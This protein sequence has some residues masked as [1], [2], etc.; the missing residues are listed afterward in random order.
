MKV[1]S[2]VGARPQFIKAAAVS[3]LLR[4]DHIEVL[5]HT[6]QH[7]DDTLSGIFFR[8][9]ALPR[10]EIQ[11]GIGSGSHAEQTAGMLIGLERAM[12]AERPDWVLVYGDTNS[13]L[14]GA[15]AAAKLGIKLAHVEAGLRSFNRALPEE[16]NRVVTDHLADVLLCPT[17]TAMGHLRHE[18]LGERACL[19]GDVMVDILNQSLPYAEWRTWLAGQVTDGWPVSALD[20][21]RYALLT[22]HRP[23]NT[24]DLTRLGRILCAV[25][26]IDLPVLF[27]A[28]PRTL[29]ALRAANLRTPANMWLCQPAPYLAMLGLERDARV[30][31]TDSGGVQKEAYILGVPCVTLRAETEWPETLHDGWNVLVD[32][33]PAQIVAAVQRSRPIG[34]RGTPFGDGHAAEAVVRVLVGVLAEART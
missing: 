8:E 18:G 14:A 32:T 17:D 24:D 6:G 20:P 21:G 30:I 11:L 31:L 5:V 15:L 26:E 3:Y 19:I 12:L 29:K 1:L 16:H 2:V 33:D 23:G 25:E 22:V 28:H 9:L 27:P 7:Y 10:P 4:Q 34:D 13:T